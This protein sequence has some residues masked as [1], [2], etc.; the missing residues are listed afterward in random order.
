MRFNSVNE[1]NCAQQK[2]WQHKLFHYCG[3]PTLAF[4][5]CYGG[6]KEPEK[7]QLQQQRG[8]LQDLLI[9]QQC[10]L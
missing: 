2:K 4:Q 6:W 9:F 5:K 7:Y 10:A 3:G 1:V 8:F